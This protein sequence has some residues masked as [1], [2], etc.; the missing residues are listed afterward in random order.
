MKFIYPLII[1]SLLIINGCAPTPKTETP[2]DS[3]TITEAAASTYNQH[4]QQVIS[5]FPDYSSVL[6]TDN[7]F[8]AEVAAGIDNL[9]AQYD[10]LQLLIFKTAYHRE[11]EYEGDYGEIV[12]TQDVTETWFFDL[13]YKLKAYSRK[14]YREGEGRESKLLIVFFEKDSLVALSDWRKDDG[15]IGLEFSKKLLSSKCPKCGTDTERE[16]GS[17]GKLINYFNSDDYDEFN[18]SFITN[19][20]DLIDTDLWAKA[21]QTGEVFSVLENIEE[22]PDGEGK[23]YTIEYAVSE[24][25]LSYHK[26]TA[27]V[28]LFN[29]S[30][31]EIS[32]SQARFYLDGDEQGNYRTESML[33]SEAAYF[34]LYTKFVPVGPGVYE[35]YAL[36]FTKDAQLKNNLQI[37]SSYPSSGPDGSGTD[38]DYNY[39]A[40]TRML[41]V[42]RT[43]ITWDEESEQE[44]R[45]DETTLYK[46][47]KEGSIIVQ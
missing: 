16:A 29:Y 39:D 38:Y 47:D 7:P 45:K 43:T 5:N 8:E 24:E 32:E 26:F 17:D 22:W 4:Y 18:R 1:L 44:V 19:L 13:T 40:E 41:T 25:L 27:F 9:V 3:L 30:S 23:P 21:E 15:Q 11:R 6:I 20:S 42:T 36:S 37:G 28:D 31:T 46:L 12:E 34:L 33:E 10:P 2:V 35:L 14:Y